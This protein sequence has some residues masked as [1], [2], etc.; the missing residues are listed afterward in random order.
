MSHLPEPRR[1]FLPLLKTIAIEMAGWLLIVLG[2][3][4]LVL[5]GPGLLFLVAG[6]AMLSLRYR[7]ARRILRPV[8]S[9]AFYLAAK[10]VQSWPRIV[11]GLLGALAVA[12]AGVLWGIGFPEPAWWPVSSRWWLPGGWGTGATLIASGALALG[13]IAYSFH[14]FRGHREFDADAP[15]LSHL[16]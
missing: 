7:W 11:L 3:A 1:S 12:S 8:R 2:V 5:P 9:R 4:A 6:F 10:A 15:P 14:R 13:L 16:S